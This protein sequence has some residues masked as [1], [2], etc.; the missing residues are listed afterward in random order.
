MDQIIM[1]ELDVKIDR[2]IRELQ[3][4][5]SQ[6]NLLVQKLRDTQADQSRLEKNNKIVACKMRE[7]ISQFKEQCDE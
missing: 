4:L 7:I 3:Q 5:R 2:L 6:N 1:N